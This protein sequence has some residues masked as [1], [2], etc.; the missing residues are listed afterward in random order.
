MMKIDE[1]IDDIVF[2]SFRE[3]ES[4]K[5]IGLTLKS[6]NFLVKGFD[7]FGVWLSH[8]GLF[9]VNE[10]DDDGKPIPPKKQSRQQIE[11][12]FLV[13]WENIITIMHFPGREGYDFPNEFEKDFGF[14]IKAKK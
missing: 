12:N 6:G 8:P 4:L 7:Q 9:F 2:I 10:T 3:P 1:I 14:E 5:D 11:A 13:R